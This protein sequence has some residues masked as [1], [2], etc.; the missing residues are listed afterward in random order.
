M[1]CFTKPVI[2]V[3]ATKIFA[4]AGKADHQYLVYSMNLKASEALAMVLPLPVKAGSDENAVKFISLKDYPEFFTDMESGFPAP[5]SAG[6]SEGVLKWHA[7]SA[8]ALPVVE[9]GNFEASFVP[10]VKDFSRLDERFRLPEGAWKKL[11]AYKDFGFAVFKLK[12]GSQQVHPMAFSFPRRDIHSLFFPTVHIHDG[13]VHSEAEF[14]HVLY[15]QPNE[16]EPLKYD[17]KRAWIE[18]SG[19]AIS[20]MRVAKAE[21]IVEPNQHCYKTTMDGHLP[22]RDTSVALES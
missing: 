3:T 9:V 8:A 11:P 7:N 16:G 20:F 19:H 22:N 21:A 2:S 5:V 15:C 12:P 14:D 1:C 10:T 13:K 4:R 6:R 17:S 18:S